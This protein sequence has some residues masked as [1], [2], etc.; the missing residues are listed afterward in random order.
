[1]F[2]LLSGNLQ[3]QADATRRD[4]QRGAWRRLVLLVARVT[5]HLPSVPVSGAASAPSASVSRRRAAMR[6]LPPGREDAAAHEI[7]SP[8]LRR[9]AFGSRKAH[10]MV[11]ITRMQWRPKAP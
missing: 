10:E 3:N 7:G 6:V 2:G 1:M 4:A 9:G 8:F 11:Q 5:G